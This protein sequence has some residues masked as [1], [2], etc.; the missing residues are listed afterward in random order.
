MKY[1]KEKCQPHSIWGG[2]IFIHKNIGT[3]WWVIS[4]DDKWML[5]N[6][7]Y[8]VDGWMSSNPKTEFQIKNKFEE[9]TEDEV[10]L[11]LI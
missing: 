4:N 9:I 7:R 3:K 2:I 10:F 5:E 1:Y 8:L 11:E 6:S